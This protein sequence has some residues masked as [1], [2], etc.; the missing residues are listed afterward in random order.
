MAS[1]RWT[2]SAVPSTCIHS[3]KKPSFSTHSEARGSRARF[4]AFIAVSLVLTRIRPSAST[5][6]VTGDSW[7]RPSVRVV[8]STAWWWT[9]RNSL[10]CCGSTS[11]VQSD[12]ALYLVLVHDR[13][14]VAVRQAVLVGQP[15]STFGTPKERGA[16]LKA[17]EPLSE[18][19]SGD[20]GDAGDQVLVHL[21]RV[22]Q[23]QVAPPGA[24]QGGAGEPLPN[25]TAPLRGA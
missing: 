2:I 1:G 14:G 9:R 6:A 22:E 24:A 15:V 8:A 5:P 20:R 23:R 19:T 13:A 25:E 4:L 11:E 7:G 16:V 17:P 18:V 21:R 10:A 3:P 12:A